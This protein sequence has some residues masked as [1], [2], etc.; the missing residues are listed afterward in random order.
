[1]RITTRAL[2]RLTP[3]E[4][5]DLRYVFDLFSSSSHGSIAPVSSSKS[6]S[7]KTTDE[8]ASK[9]ESIYK[10][11]V[12]INWPELYLFSILFIAGLMIPIQR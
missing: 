11:G 9:Y 7:G 8:D 5:R 2:A 1:M 6:G 12:F 10:E 4:I 3:Q